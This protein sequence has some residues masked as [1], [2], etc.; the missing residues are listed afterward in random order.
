MLQ[1]A[2]DKKFDTLLVYKL[3]RLG[4][5]A[6]IILNAVYELEQYGVQ[7]K[8]MTEPFDTGDPSGRFL[9]TIL[10]GVA[11]LE[12]SNILDRMWHGANRA[13][14]LG[15][16]LGGIVPYGYIVN[17]EG[18]LETSNTTIPSFNMTEV[19]VVKMIFSL[20]VDKHMSTIKICDYLN[21]LSL[22]P[23][24]ALQGRQV[25]RGKRK[26]NTAGRWAPHQIGRMLKN[27]TYKGIHYY[28]KRSNK[29]RE[30]IPRIVPAII[31]PAIWEKAQ[32]IIKENTIGSMR[33][34]KHNYLLTGLIK[35]GHCGHNYMGT[36]YNAYP[37]GEKLYYVCIGKQRYKSIEKC[38]SKNI[39][40]AWLENMIWND[41]LKFIKNPGE[42][43]KAINIQLRDI[44]SKNETLHTELKLITSA[45]KQKESERQSILD[46][47]RK[48]L[49]SSADIETQFTKIKDETNSLLKRKTDLENSLNVSTTT[50]NRASCAED[51]LKY[52]KNKIKD[53]N[54]SFEQKREIVKSLVKQITIETTFINDR[55]HANI[56]V[57]YVFD[58]PKLQ[59]ARTGI[60]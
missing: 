46:L 33:N 21:D 30:L 48:K 34:K 28:G 27:T 5:S 25:S 56:K 23:S 58:S 47:F 4:R 12:R 44:I 7:V 29:K 26:E 59:N 36:G 51:Y 50:I 11:D 15:K 55:P 38:K 24:Y 41:C 57:Q 9:L 52:L 53:G 49:I 20:C 16:W 37:T 40:A 31:E 32:I 6:R 1:D 17:E 2:K 14:R 13:A 43:I 45:L 54:P 22:P 3:D 10:A 18:F 39:S 42:A 35:C 60:S 8:S 19:D